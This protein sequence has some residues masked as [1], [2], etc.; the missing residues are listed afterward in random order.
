VHRVCVFAGSRAGQRPDF[1][2][3]ARAL[4]GAVA[5]RGWGLVYGGSVHGTMGAVADA[6]LAAGGEVQ[7]VIPRAGERL[8]DEL[9]HPGLT[10][11]FVVASMHERKAKMHALADA[12]VV[13]PGGFGTADE[14]FE[15]ITWRQLGLHHKAIG[16]LDVDGYWQ[17]LLRWIDRAVADG[18]VDPG[19]ATALYVSPDVEMLLDA[20][21]PAAR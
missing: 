9:A 1:V 10:R 7:G 2:A 12:F 4:G 13:L 3:A 17:P 20:V 14:T 16:F 19:H 5:R 6:A 15:A 18:F 21:G 8:S 11:L